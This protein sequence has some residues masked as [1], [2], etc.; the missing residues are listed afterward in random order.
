MK[1][2]KYITVLLVSIMLAVSVVGVAFASTVRYDE[3]SAAYKSGKYYEKLINV[4]LTGDLRADIVNVAVSQIGY[5]EGNEESHWSGE[6]EGDMDY[7]E[8]G[9]WYTENVLPTL[10]PSAW[11]AVFV[12]WCARMANVPEDVISNAINAKPGTDTM[13]H[14]RNLAAVYERTENNNYKLGYIPLPGDL[15]FFDWDKK[16]DSWSHVGIVI[17]VV[18]DIV[19]T[20]EGNSGNGVS[21]RTYRLDEMVIRAYGVPKYASDINHTDI[22]GTPVYSSFESSKAHKHEWKSVERSTCNTRGTKKCTGCG[23]TDVMYELGHQYWVWGD[24]L[25]DEDK[26][27]HMHIDKPATCTEEGQRS[28]HCIRCEH[29]DKIQ[30]IASLGHITESDWITVKVATYYEDG[31]EQ[32]ICSV[33]L[34]VAEERIVPKLIDTTPPTGSVTIFDNASNGFNNAE[35][36]GAIVNKAPTVKIEANDVGMGISGIYYTVSNKPLTLDEVKE[37]TDWIKGVCYTPEG[38][39]VYYV[40]A[41]LVDKADNVSY[42]SSVG[43]VLDTKMPVVSGLEDGKTYCS[44]VHFT[45]NEEVE[46]KVNSTVVGI[47]ANGEYVLFGTSGYTVEIKDKAGN[48]V[49]FSVQVNSTHTAGSPIVTVEPTCTK[50]GTKAMKCTVCDHTIKTESIKALGHDDG[51]WSTTKQA[52]CTESGTKIRSCTICDGVLETVTQE[53]YGHIKSSW[54]V[55]KEE[56]CTEDGKE[57][58]YCLTCL[59]TVEEKVIPATG[60]VLGGWIVSQPQTC[61]D[62][63]ILVRRCIVCR[64]D[65][66]SDVIPKEGHTPGDWTTQSSATCTEDGKRVKHCKTCSEVLEEQITERLGHNYVNSKCEVC[67]RPSPVLIITVSATALA[68]ML[69]IVVADV[70]KHRKSTKRRL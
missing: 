70:S 34:G 17:D 35:T 10:V 65:V 6:F 19:F 58:I 1:I 64:E 11:C 32:Q 15:I 24:V 55:T 46:V 25:N 59:A 66:E 36:I 9:R 62:D 49:K 30:P 7:T 43:F 42:L 51:E 13:R 44:N 57:E 50:A 28:F 39:G 29:K 23:Q 33:C 69:L 68:I 5:T 8:Y 4:E 12:S 60:H 27:I 22:Y 37:I 16:F 47:N 53:A 67:S 18:D 3:G 54:T 31:I 41:K 52:T 21:L 14:F 56:T 26:L 61:M 38:D 20:V 48:A 45:V 63:G 40:Y 2:V